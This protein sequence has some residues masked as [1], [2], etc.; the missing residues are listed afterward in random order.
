MSKLDKQ[1]G[2]YFNSIVYMCIIRL[3]FLSSLSYY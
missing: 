2:H 3:P 1:K